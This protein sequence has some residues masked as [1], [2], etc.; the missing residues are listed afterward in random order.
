MTEGL[1]IQDHE[2]TIIWFNAAA[3]RLLKI[4]PG[5]L[6]GRAASDPRWRY[7]DADGFELASDQTPVERCLRTRREIKN[8]LMRVD[9]GERDEVWLDVSATPTM[10]D[11][12]PA[13]ITVFR[14]VT[15]ERHARSELAQTIIEINQTLVQRNLPNDGAVRFATRMASMTS[16]SAIGGDFL[17]A[18]RIDESRY[19]FFIGDACGHGVQ[20][21]GV[22][23]LARHTIGTAGALL[24]DPDHVLSHLHSVLE[25]EW[26]DTF[27]TAIYGYIDV[28]ADHVTVRIAMGG[29]PHPVLISERNTRRVGTVG[30]IIGMVQN[31]PRPVDSFDLGPGDR[32]ILFT[33]GLTDTRFVQAE[34]LELLKPIKP[35][36]PVDEVAQLTLDLSERESMLNEAGDDVAVLVV[37]FD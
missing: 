27:V 20:S 32:L 6:I 35:G 23:A 4:A 17:G 19:G 15:Y 21:A 2:G 34:A 7:V 1:T 30:P 10:R 22:S 11:G 9:T 25:R 31:T 33:D 5:E 37:G 26:P 29:H 16:Q 13:V 8:V 24:D 3:S 18:H 36:T 14:D 12:R 28:H